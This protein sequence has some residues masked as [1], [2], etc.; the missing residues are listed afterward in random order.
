MTIFN[1]S[2]SLRLSFFCHYVV[3]YIDQILLFMWAWG[4][5]SR[6]SIWKIEKSH[7][8]SGRGGVPVKIYCIFISN[9][10]TRDDK[11]R[12][13]M[14]RVPILRDTVPIKLNYPPPRTLRVA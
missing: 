14:Q 3:K 6:R 2:Q 7:L 4:E 13:T 12:V 9:L 10:L 11:R 1:V 5:F 8:I